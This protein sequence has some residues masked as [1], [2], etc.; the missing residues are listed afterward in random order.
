MAIGDA[1]LRYSSNFNL[2]LQVFYHLGSYE[3]ALTYALFA[4]DLFNVAEKSEY[5][6]TMIGEEKQFIII[7]PSSTL[8]FI[9]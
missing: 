3:D 2:P 8:I 4:G 9:G 6:D 7:I 1:M 5:V